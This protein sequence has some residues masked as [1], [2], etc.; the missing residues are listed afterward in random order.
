VNLDVAQRILG[1]LVMLFSLSLLPPVAVSLLFQDGSHM[2]FLWAFV[3]ALAVGAL[4]WFPQRAARRELRTRDGFLIVALFWF[5]L[6]AIGALP[7][8]LTNTPHMSLTDAV[9]ESV[10]GLTTTGA[11][12]ING[13]EHLPPAINWYRNQLHWLG[14]MG[15][16]VLAVAILPML[17]IGGMQ[18]YKAETPGPGKDTK[19]TP[20]IT[21]TAKALWYAYLALTVL[22]G[23]S[24]W[25]AGM[26]PFDA[27]THAF[28]TV[29]TGG[30]SNY[31]ASIAAFHSPAIER[32]AMFFMAMAG[33]NF[34]LHFVAWRSLDP[35]VFWR[36]AEFRAYLKILV[37]LS[38]GIAT[39]LWLA[40]SYGSFWLALHHGGFHVIS[41]MTSTGL[42]SADYAAWPGALPALLI[43]IGFLGGCGGS[44]SG[45]IKTIRVVLL[46]KQAQR[47]VYRLVHPNAELPVK[48]GG[49]AVPTRVVDA[50]WGFVFIYIA[51]YVI[52]ML[53]VLA[54]GNDQVTAY[55]AVAASINNVGPALGTVAVNFAP[56]DD[57]SKWVCALA[58]IIGRLEVFTILVLL[59]PTFWRG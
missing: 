39:Y 52:L 53:L 37:V 25:L 2:A 51:A 43:F 26:G 1:I 59:T 45:G 3:I 14:G 58:M 16:V 41:T 9:F 49:K 44:T 36:D 8:L 30:F 54:A 34:A 15:V 17:G 5:G 6:S 31:D 23:A 7:F 18:L 56:L 33:A 27:I 48:V 24:Y 28:S 46:W 21:E 29:A 11:T 12:V 40:N 38:L 42:V 20:R 13:L 32:V 55:S 47:E 35:R 57:F 22:C 10:S 19:L 50:V 4:I